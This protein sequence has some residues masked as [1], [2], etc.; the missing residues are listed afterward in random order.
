MRT[1]HLIEAQDLI[2]VHNQTSREYHNATTEMVNHLT[3]L[4]DKIDS[5]ISRLL[6]MQRALAILSAENVEDFKHQ[7]GDKSFDESLHD[8]EKSLK[9]AAEAA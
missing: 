5:E 3:K 4:R 8:M 7:K 1:D 9:E 6:V 2:S